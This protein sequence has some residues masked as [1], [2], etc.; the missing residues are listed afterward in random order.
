M[1]YFII[2]LKLL[3]DASDWVD[4]VQRHSNTGG[5]NCLPTVNETSDR[6][7]CDNF[8]SSW[9]DGKTLVWSAA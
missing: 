7:L 4:Y 3:T 2:R 1:W 5:H 9:F 6:Y 8:D